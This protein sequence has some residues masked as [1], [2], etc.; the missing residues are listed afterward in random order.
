MRSLINILFYLLKPDFENTFHGYQDIEIRSKDPGV[1]KKETGEGSLNEPNLPNSICY[2]EMKVHIAWNK[3]ISSEELLDGKTKPWTKSWA[4]HLGKFLSA[5]SGCL[6]PVPPEVPVLPSSLTPSTWYSYSSPGCLSSHRV[7]VSLTWQALPHWGPYPCPM[8]SVWTPPL[9]SWHGEKHRVRNKGKRES[10]ILKR[11]PIFS[12]RDLAGRQRGASLRVT[13]K[14]PSLRAMP[15]SRGTDP[16][17][18]K[19]PLKS[20]PPRTRPQ[21]GEGKRVKGGNTEQS[22]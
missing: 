3:L 9:T 6:K 20:W 7:G 16:M 4:W 5:C 12:P 1:R 14:G 10:R 22:E 15:E 8:L 2:M 17:D 13:A 19:N 11:Y 21:S 18:T